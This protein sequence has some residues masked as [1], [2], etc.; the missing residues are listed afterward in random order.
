MFD[1]VATK[2]S[3]SSA[4]CG[5][6]LRARNACARRSQSAAIPCSSGRPAA[7][8]SV[9]CPAISTGGGV[10]GRTLLAER[11]LPRQ[12]PI[13]GVQHRH[14]LARTQ[15]DRAIERR[16]RAPV[17]LAQDLRRRNIA[18]HPLGDCEASVVGTVVDQDDLSR[19]RGLRE[20]TGERRLDVALMIVQRHHDRY[21]HVA[22]ARHRRRG[23]RPRPE[24][25][26]QRRHAT[27]ESGPAGSPSSSSSA[28]MRQ[29]AAA[30]E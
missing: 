3:L 12:E 8:L 10:A 9:T 4:S 24:Q 15:R 23:A 26:L 14:E 17:V 7:S 5:S 21:R 18:Q 22:R 29:R 28:A 11:E 6:A 16:M 30:S 2:F 25:A 1:V 20:H 13:V 19:R 27:S